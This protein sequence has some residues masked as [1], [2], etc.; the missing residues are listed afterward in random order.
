MLLFSTVHNVHIIYPK[1]GLQHCDKVRTSLM[2]N[3]KI[4]YDS[5]FLEKTLNDNN[6]RINVINAA[7]HPY[8]RKMDVCAKPHACDIDMIKEMLRILEG[9]VFGSHYIVIVSRLHTHWC[10]AISLNTFQYK[11]NF[12]FSITYQKKRKY[13]DPDKIDLCAYI[14]IIYQYY[15][16]LLQNLS[17]RRIILSA[18]A[19]KHAVCFCIT[20]TYILS[21]CPKREIEISQQIILH[22]SK[23][24]VCP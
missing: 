16:V 24:Q 2:V 23:R 11:R 7:E 5:K 14:L 10:V 15:R 13:C 1:F 22:N 17:Q 4:W 9:N 21:K 3:T 20:L 6:N 18:K 12:Q 19:L 8:K